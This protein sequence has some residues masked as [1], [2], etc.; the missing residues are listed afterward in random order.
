MNEAGVAIVVAVIAA[1]AAIAAALLGRKVEQ[2]TRTTN[3]HTIGEII[4]SM[5]TIV[6]HHNRDPYAHK[7]AEDLEERP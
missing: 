6:Q 1:T 5:L 7:N 3:G 2:R 4:E